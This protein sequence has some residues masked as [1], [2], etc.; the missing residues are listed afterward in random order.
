MEWYSILLIILGLILFLFITGIPVAFAF[1]LLNI[2]GLYIW[3]GGEKSWHILVLSAFEVLT[4]YEML[5]VLFFILMG[6]V[7]YHSGVVREVFELVDV[8]FGG[9][10]G[11]LSYITVV[12]SV[13]MAA[14]SGSILGVGAAMGATLGPEMR[15]KGYH[16]SL[17][18]GPIVGGACLAQLIPPSAMTVLLATLAR[19]PVGKMLMAGIGPG[20]LL[21]A[22]YMIYIFIR[23]SRNPDLAPLYTVR[24]I[25]TSAKIASVMR[26]VPIGI[27]F[28]LVV[29]TMIL[30]IATPTEASGLGALGAFVVPSFYRRL[31]W[32]NVNK[33]VLASGELIGMIFLICMG[34]KCFS[35]LLAATG[36]ADGMLA[37]VL[38]ANLPPWALIVIMQVIVLFMGMIMDNISIMMITLPIFMPVL[39]VIGFNPVLFGILFLLNIGVAL[40]SPPFGLL[41]FVMKGVSPSEISIG[42][43]YRISFPWALMMLGAMGLVAAI[44]EIALWLPKILH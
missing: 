27:L 19:L 4:I 25:S 2:I 17:Y 26:M 34:S 13:I 8:F 37:A 40:L 39:A 1:L 42:T 9:V 11:R 20:L 44:P 33:A 36:A 29:G 5:A 24:H 43:I 31:N 21:A 28:F 30:G 3:L 15:E 10:R 38:G 23:V 7:L 22:M 41:I 12:V 14:I 18:I 35:Q 16:E 32:R 6:E